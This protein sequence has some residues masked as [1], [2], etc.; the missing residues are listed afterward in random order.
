[1]IG[2]YSVFDFAVFPFVIRRNPPRF[3]R[4]QVDLVRLLTL[5]DWLTASWLGFIG[6]VAIF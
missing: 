1:V 3:S 4:L 6:Y 2:D 5:R